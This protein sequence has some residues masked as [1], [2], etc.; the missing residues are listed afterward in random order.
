MKEVSKY[1]GKII[2]KLLNYIFMS[3]ENLKTDEEKIKDAFND[4]KSLGWVK[5]HRKNNTGIG[6]TFEDLLGVE[7]N[8]DKLPDFKGFE[9]K[10]MRS[11]AT[12][13]LTLFTKSPSGPRGANKFLRD[14]FGDVDPNNS[15]IKKLHTSIFTNPNSYLSKYRFSLKNDRV[16]K[17]VS[18]VVTDMNGIL[19]DKS[20]YWSYADLKSAL[21]KKL[22]ALFYVKADSRKDTNGDEEFHYTSATIFYSISF[23][24]FLDFIDDNKLMIDI[25]IGSYKS[26]TNLGKVH[27]HGTGFRVKVKNLDGLYNK[28]III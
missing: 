12:N 3:K 17:I 8:N 5:S 25:R 21:T 23:D 14:K 19:I 20:V 18:I 28:K 24:D 27:D 13:Y 26:G 7:E 4:I 1:I 10:T 11:L 15:A 2:Y 22:D 6:K 16:N 9:V